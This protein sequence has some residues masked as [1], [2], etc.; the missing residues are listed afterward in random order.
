MA[1]N[2]PHIGDLENRLGRHY[3]RFSTSEPAAPLVAQS[4]ARR[5]SRN[6]GSNRRSRVSEREVAGA[7]CKPSL[8]AAGYIWNTPCAPDPPA[9]W[10]PLSKTQVA[11]S[12]EG[13][14]PTVCAFATAV[15]PQVVPSIVASAVLLPT[16]PLALPP[17]PLPSPPLPV[18]SPTVPVPSPLPVP[19]PPP[20]P[21]VPMGNGFAVPGFIAITGAPGSGT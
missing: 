5:K 4:L 21:P 19:S 14:T 13:L 6:G 10:Q 20:P 2:Y 12:A 1:A 3:S 8:K 17:S 9:F 11:A 16:F 7:V 18:R 15:A